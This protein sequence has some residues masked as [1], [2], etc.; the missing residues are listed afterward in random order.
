M[1]EWPDMKLDWFRL[2]NP[3]PSSVEKLYLKF[4]QTVYYD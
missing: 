2:S 1:Q 4:S 3:L